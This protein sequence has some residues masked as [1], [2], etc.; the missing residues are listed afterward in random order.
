[1]AYPTL[2]QVGLLELG[3]VVLVMF[4]L[5]VLWIISRSRYVPGMPGKIAVFSTL[6]TWLFGTE[7]PRLLLFMLALICYLVIL[8]FFLGCHISAFAPYYP[9]C[10]A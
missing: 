8:Y 1:M 7:D 6:S 9:P 4:L 10:S 5:L 2:T 3:I